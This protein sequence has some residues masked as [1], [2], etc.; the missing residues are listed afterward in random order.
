MAK[1]TRQD[2]I[3]DL[4]SEIQTQGWEEYETSSGKFYMED[5]NSYSFH[6]YFVYNDD[7]F[8]GPTFDEIT[9]NL[10]DRV[11]SLL[12]NE[13][14]L[15]F[16]E[17]NI[18]K[19]FGRMR[20]ENLEFLETD[21]NKGF[22]GECFNELAKMNC[23]RSNM[24]SRFLIRL[25]EEYPVYENLYK[26]GFKISDVADQIRNPLSLD[27]RE[28]FGFETKRQL[29]F[30]KMFYV[31]D[32]NQVSYRHI[33]ARFVSNL[34]ND[35]V[36][37]ILDLYQ[38]AKE[39][40]YHYGLRKSSGILEDL[41][42]TWSNY[43]DVTLVRFFNDISQ[44]DPGRQLDK[45][46]LIDY[47]YYEVDVR[48]GMT[49]PTAARNIYRDY[50]RM[51]GKLTGGTFK[52]F[53]RYPKSLMLKHDICTKYVNVCGAVQPETF[54]EVYKCIKHLEGKIGRTGYSIVLPKEPEDIIQEGEELCHCV[55]S[56]L[57]SI[58]NG[59]CL[60]AFLRKDPETP[61]YTLEFRENTLVQFAGYQNCEPDEDA[62][63]AITKFAESFNIIEDWN[64]HTT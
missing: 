12:R 49:S 45:K 61:L 55:K 33:T 23:E 4:I 40:D 37:E 28:A 27:V 51:A 39:L 53:D 16:S 56:Y 15:K 52:H 57:E 35:E 14:P 41:I 19:S 54:T 29:K 10:K 21:E 1:R 26:Q 3:R 25:M 63:A 36:N 46:R 31:G 59:D 24:V 32:D 48:Q 50:V 58:A 44:I 7:M 18:V 64:G 2:E 34:T 13:K 5:K 60:I 30:F 11:V 9:Y 38:Y 42:S 43:K 22:Y 8:K 20:A 47:L 62:K 6:T 17:D